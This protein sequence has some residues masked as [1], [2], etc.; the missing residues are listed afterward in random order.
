MPNEKQYDWVAMP[1]LPLRG[2]SVFPGMLLTFDVERSASV[3]AVNTAVRTDHLI[4][5][6]AQRDIS[7]DV[8]EEKD[9]Y[10]VG[11]VCRIRQQLRAGNGGCRVMVEGL[12][13]A[14]TESIDTGCLLYTSDAADE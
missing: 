6:A 10:R 5:L 9:I 7:V 3:A 11:T 1:M 4:F 8:P 13:R 2:L 12:Y 14:E